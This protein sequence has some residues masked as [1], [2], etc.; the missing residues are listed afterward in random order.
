TAQIDSAGLISIRIAGHTS[1]AT[2][3]TASTR[4]AAWPI[5]SL[6]SSVIAVARGG[7]AIRIEAVARAE[8][9]NPTDEAVTGSIT[10]HR[11]TVSASAATG[12]A[13]TPTKR[14]ASS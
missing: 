13:R 10:D 2:A 6:L 14:A 12:E 9:M 5:R 11:A 3:G 8:S 7:A 4:A 1:W